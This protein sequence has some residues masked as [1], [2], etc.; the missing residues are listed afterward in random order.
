MGD[1]ADVKPGICKSFVNIED[2]FDVAEQIGDGQYAKVFR[3]T[4]KE[5]GVDVAMKIIKKRKKGI[6]H[7]IRE[8]RD[9]LVLCAHPQILKL[10]EVYESELEIYL[11]TELLSGGTLWDRVLSG[12]VS[13]ERIASNIFRQLLFAL[14]NVHSKNV[15]HRDI[16]PQNVMFLEANTVTGLRL[17]DFGT[18]VKQ[19]KEVEIDKQVGT[20]K[21]MAPEMA[22]KKVYDEKVDMWSLGVVLYIMLSGL[23]P[24]TG[25]GTSL[26]VAIREAK[27]DYSAPPWQVVS[28][29]AKDLLKKILVK[30]PKDRL[31]AEEAAKHAWVVRA[32]DQFSGYYLPDRR[33]IKDPYAL[34]KKFNAKRLLC[35]AVWA[36]VAAFAM[37]RLAHNPVNR[38]ADIYL[39]NS[40]NVALSPMSAMSGGGSTLAGSA[41]R[42]LTR[43]SPGRISRSPNAGSRP[44]SSGG[45]GGIGALRKS[46]ARCG[47]CGLL[48][49]PDEAISTSSQQ[50]HY[51][52]FTCALC[53][54]PIQGSYVEGPD[55]RPYHSVCMAEPH[56]TNRPAQNVCAGCGKPVVSG[57]TALGAH[58]HDRC[59]TCKICSMPIT[60]DS[61]YLSEGGEP[62]HK[63]CLTKLHAQEPWRL[64]APVVTGRRPSIESQAHSTMGGSEYSAISPPGSYRPSSVRS[65]GGWDAQSTTSSY[66]PTTTTT[67]E[68]NPVVGAHHHRPMRV[69]GGGGGPPS[70]TASS[71]N[72]GFRSKFCHVC[73]ARHPNATSR[74]C[75]ECGEARV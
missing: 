48:V 72:G 10:H 52:C 50:F 58:Y 63:S 18:A 36:H 39:Q 28:T 11:A 2:V 35:G 29:Q 3:A 27:V 24:F 47:N 25:Q 37:M 30:N 51:A 19:K 46:G 22:N 4:E 41:G 1:I 33:N 23:E 69:A 62:Y 44:T 61:N 60:E 40:A 14:G 12:Q 42:S 70:S 64:S 55:G 71:S 9:L 5:T 66:A 57:I 7:A 21:F 74:F 43:L 26:F 31:S 53:G 56:L 59:F 34:I 75:V 49:T 38:A 67:S 17:I 45:G 16:K 32:K 54:H 20:V 13:T 73:G 68:L 8:E 6:T 15:I 65:S